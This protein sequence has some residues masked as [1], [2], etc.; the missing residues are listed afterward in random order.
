VRA[1]CRPKAEALR[2]KRRIEDGREHRMQRLLNQAVDDV[3]LPR[4]M[5]GPSRNRLR[6]WPRLA[7]AGSAHHCWHG[8][9]SPPHLRLH[10]LVVLD[11][12]LFGELV[13]MQAPDAIR[14]DSASQRTP[15]LFG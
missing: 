13:R 15:L 14:S 8:C 7:S 10:L 6:Y 9:R 12:A 4:S 11:F 5:F 3:V 2:D 1:A